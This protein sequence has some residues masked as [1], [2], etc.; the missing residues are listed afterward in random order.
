[1]SLNKWPCVPDGFSSILP[2]DLPSFLQ[3]GATRAVGRPLS[4]IDPRKE[5]RIDAIDRFDSY[6]SFCRCLRGGCIDRQLN[7]N[8]DANCTMCD[9]G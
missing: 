1:M 8:C 4:I 7:I 5:S 9:C 2:G 3:T 6:Q